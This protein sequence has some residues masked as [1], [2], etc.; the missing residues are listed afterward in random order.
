MQGMEDTWQDF[1]CGKSN[2]NFQEASAILALKNTKLDENKILFFIFILFPLLSYCNFKVIN[3]NCKNHKREAT[4]SQSTNAIKSL[5][6]CG[7]F[8]ICVTETVTLPV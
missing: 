7:R 5:F 1:S 8:S 3:Y 4:E 6:L 2:V